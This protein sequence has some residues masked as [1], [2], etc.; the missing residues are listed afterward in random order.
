MAANLIDNAITHNIEG[1]WVSVRTGCS[2]G[3]VKLLVA[4]SGPVVPPERVPELYEPFRRLDGQRTAD[5]RGLGLGL[6]IA[7][8][9][10][11]AHGARIESE[12]GAGGGL[13]IEVSFPAAGS[14]RVLPGL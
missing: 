1:G 13:E 14:E 7:K 6:S 12:P 2:G 8:A 10:I 9:I 11:D 3:L 4:N 5:G